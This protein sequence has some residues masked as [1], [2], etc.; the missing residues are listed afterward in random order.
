MTKATFSSQQIMVKQELAQNPSLFMQE[1]NT[2][3]KLVPVMSGEHIKSEN[4][5]KSKRVRIVL[6]S[7]GLCIVIAI[8][9]LIVIIALLTLSSVSQAQE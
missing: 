9:V 1:K 3:G 7:A 5:L 2:Q 8:G 4:P 6:V